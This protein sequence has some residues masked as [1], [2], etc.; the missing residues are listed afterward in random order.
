MQTRVYDGNHEK[1]ILKTDDPLEIIFAAN[2]IANMWDKE[3]SKEFKDV[4]RHAQLLKAFFED[5]SSK[6]PEIQ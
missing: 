4:V 6:N 5:N 2:H 1:I 3:V